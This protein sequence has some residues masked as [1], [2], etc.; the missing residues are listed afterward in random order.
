L[1]GLP[2]LYLAHAKEDIG[3]HVEQRRH[4]VIKEQFEKAPTEPM[5]LKLI[6]KS[7]TCG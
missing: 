6:E 4:R 7:K 3:A 5:Y 1:V 2:L